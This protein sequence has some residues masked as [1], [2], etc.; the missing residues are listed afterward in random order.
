MG[1]KGA[2]FCYYRVYPCTS[3]RIDRIFTGKKLARSRIRVFTGIEY[4]PLIFYMVS[5]A[6]SMDSSKQPRLLRKKSEAAT[7]YNIEG[8]GQPK[9][10]LPAT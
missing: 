2:T 9:R 7:N 8:D 4:R 6:R 10:Q 3:S 1:K 5:P